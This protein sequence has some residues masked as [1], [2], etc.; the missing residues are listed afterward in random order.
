MKK[1][2][3]VGLS[4]L[5]LD[6]LTK[7]F[8]LDKSILSKNFKLYFWAINSTLFYIIAGAILLL[9][10]FLLIKSW[11][12]NNFLLNTGL[13]LIITGGLSNLFDRIFFGYVIDWIRVF[14]LPLSIF[15]IAD[16]MIFGGLLCL[17]FHLLKSR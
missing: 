14:F 9:F 8:V 3:L 2:L 6:R 4:L 7:W 1:T 17:I 11:S 10:I 12:N 16:L 15:N 5:I 13:F